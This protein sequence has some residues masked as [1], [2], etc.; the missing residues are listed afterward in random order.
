MKTVVK[1]VLLSCVVALLTG[2]GV[3][4]KWTLQSIKPESEK[5]HFDLQ[6]MCLMSDGSF[7]A[8]AEEEGKSKC[9]SGTY[10]YDGKTKLLTFKTDGK[11]RAYHAEVSCPGTMK[12]TPTVAG[13]SW[14]ATLKHSACPKDK[15]CCAGNPCPAKPCDMKKCPAAKAGAAP[16]PAHKAAKPAEPK[17]GEK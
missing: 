4:G 1:V 14:S 6:C 12:V 8:A 2:C 9:L 13:E 15:C 7:R 17:Q 11:E 16:C 5:A 3:T 10:T